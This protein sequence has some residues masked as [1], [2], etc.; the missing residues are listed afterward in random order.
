MQEEI[1]ELLNKIKK[2]ELDDFLDSEDSIELIIEILRRYDCLGFAVDQL[3]NCFYDVFQGAVEDD[4]ARGMYD[5]AVELRYEFLNKQNEKDIKKLINDSEILYND[6]LMA[7]IPLC[8]D[9]ERSLLESIG[10]LTI[11]DNSAI[12]V[13]EKFIEDYREDN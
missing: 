8:S 3:Y 7:G 11:N 1:K 5:L 9:V 13:L 6:M 4:I 10:R 12:K 2:T